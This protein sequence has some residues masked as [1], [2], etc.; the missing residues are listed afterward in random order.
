MRGEPPA[1]DPRAFAIR[2][3]VR[4]DIP[5]IAAVH[6]A[7]WRDHYTGLIEQR[8]IDERTIGVRCAQWNAWIDET[9]RLTFVAAERSGPLLG[10]ISALVLSPAHNGYD[11]YLQLLYLIAKAKGYG[12][13][14]ALL[15]TAAENLARAGCRTMALRVMR[16]NPARAFYERLGASLVPDDIS[17]DAGQFDDVVYAFPDLRVLF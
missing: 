16:H 4:D 12:I 11:S 17:P 6:V 7:S 13:G 14:R 5:A 15:A 9:G 1:F 2:P 8:L 10:F 3:A